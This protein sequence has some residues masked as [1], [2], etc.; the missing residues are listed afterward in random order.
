MRTE[1]LITKSL[2]TTADEKKVLMAVDV[3]ETLTSRI[4]NIV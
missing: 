1:V 3:L 2:L 4:S